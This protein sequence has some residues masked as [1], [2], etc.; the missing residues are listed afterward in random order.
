MNNEH[1]VTKRTSFCGALFTICLGS[2]ESNEI[3]YALIAFFS[4]GERFAFADWQ[5]F[6]IK[7]RKYQ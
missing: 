1:P 5:S 4:Q 7:R 6:F 2:M 3:A